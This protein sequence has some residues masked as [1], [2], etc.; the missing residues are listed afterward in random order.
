MN[1]TYQSIG[2]FIDGGYYAKVNEAL[3]EQLSLNI[4]ISGIMNFIRRQVSQ[5]SR[6]PLADCQITE[7]HYFRGR[8]RVNE[9]NSKHLLFCE[10]KFEDT[11]IENDVIFHYKHLRE[12]QKNGAITVVEKGIDVWFAL[13]AYELATIRKFNYVVLITGDADHEMLIRK[14]KALKIHTILLTWDVLNDKSTSTAKLLREEAC[15][16]LEISDLLVEDK[17]LLQQICK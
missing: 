13:E 16:H 12:I 1:D 15:M 6:S 7:S 10:R 17:A 8:Y 3:E 11:L 5:V 14:L 9:A 2:L 4:N